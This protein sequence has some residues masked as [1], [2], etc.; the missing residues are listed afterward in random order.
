M[1]S[2]EI[3]VSGAAWLSLF[4]I[5]AGV[6]GCL[7]A[8]GGAWAVHWFVRRPECS[9]PTAQ[10]AVSIL[11]PLCGAEPQLS[12]NIESFLIQNY[13]GK[14][15]VIF[16]VQD[17]EDGAIPI[18][19]SLMARYPALELH[20]VVNGAIH[21][22]NRKLSNLINMATLIRHPL[23]VLADSDVAVG[24]EYLHTLAAALSEPGV[25]AVTCLYRGLDIGGFWSR[26]AAM[27][28]HDHFLPGAVV[29][30]ALGLAQPCVGQTI[31]L[32][33]ETLARI[34]GFEALAHQLADDYAIGDSIRQLGLRVVIPR[35]LVATLFPETSLRETVVHE[36][37]WARTIFTIDPV[38][39]F[40]SGI[41]HALPLALIGAAL[42]EFDVLGTSVV[43]AALACR[44]ILKFQVAREFGLPEPNY[45][46]TFVRDI[47]SFAV[48]FSSFFSS[49]VRWRGR[50]FVVRRDGTMAAADGAADIAG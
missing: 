32:S 31:A 19:K 26:L 5:T 36:L 48:Y 50:S 41:T 2:V 28:V 20:L 46:L 49:R 43:L 35:M 15:Q 42:R 24:P 40:G 33:R 29:G 44:V 23:V 7:Y 21:G 16:G 6:F 9:L 47:L 37:R 27:S 11:K 30:M 14:V 8:L 1:P 39:H 13:S 25:G 34:G 3:I 18:V 22:S 45:S 10:P 38:G 4:C 17:P 12:E